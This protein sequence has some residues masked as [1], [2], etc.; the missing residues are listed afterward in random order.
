[1]IHPVSASYLKSAIDR[2][3][4]AHAA[5]LLIEIDTPGGLVEDTKDVAQRM[6]AAKTPIIGY[7]TPSGARAASGGFFLLMACD[8][9]AMAPGT[10]TGAAHPVAIG[11]ENTKE[12]IEMQKAGSDLAAFMRSMAENRGRN[13]KLAETAVT[14]SV[15]WTEKEALEGNL[16]D[17]IAKD[18]ADL[19][20]KLDGRKVK[21]MGGAEAVL[22]LKGPVVPSRGMTALERLQDFLLHPMIAGLLLMIGVLGIYTE[23]TNPG[24]VLPGVVGVIAIVLFAYAAHILPVNV[25]GLLLIGA[26]IV[27]FILE[28]KITSH[29]LLGI[30]GT[31]ALVA[32]SLLLFNGPIPEL[33]L[34]LAAVLPTSL[35]LAGIMFVIVRYVVRAQKGRVAT[36]REGMV[37]E[38]G[39]ASTDLSPEGQIFVHG[40]LWNARA[41]GTIPRGARVRIRA[42]DEMLLHVEP[43]G[44][45]A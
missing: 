32:G 36:G 41:G 34:P 12:D 16:I 15:S 37:G 3:D 45:G 44:R 31:I 25:L 7:V 26:G 2:A 19:L 13:V 43:E 9:A 24:V 10:N 4:E 1:M 11:G 30:G 23:I 6:F 28:I 22:D 35:A 8:A 42:V 29:G 18:R 17:V 27:L 40:E 21:R 20:A 5:A 33:R 38:I 39:V 14:E